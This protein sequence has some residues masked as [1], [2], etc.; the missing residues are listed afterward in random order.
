[1]RTPTETWA[2]AGH[3]YYRC[4]SVVRPS[5]RQVWQNGIG[6]AMQSTAKQVL[7]HQ[8]EANAVKRDAGSRAGTPKPNL[9]PGPACQ[10][11]HHAIQELTLCYWSGTLHFFSYWLQLWTCQPFRIV[12]TNRIIYGFDHGLSWFRGSRKIVEV[13]CFFLRFLPHLLTTMGVALLR[14]LSELVAR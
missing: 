5:Y 9:H 4:T 2:D 6:H 7:R 14:W 12:V 13:R 8:A 10:H 1:M 11:G 3:I